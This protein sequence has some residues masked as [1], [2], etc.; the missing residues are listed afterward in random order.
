MPYER[1]CAR[2]ADKKHE[3]NADE[4]K[5]EFFDYEEKVINGSG[6]CELFLS[7]CIL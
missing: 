7:I 2:V 3:S 1:C 4:F 5:K 6:L